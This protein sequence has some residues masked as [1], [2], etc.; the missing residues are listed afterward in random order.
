MKENDKIETQGNGQSEK[1]MVIVILCPLP[2]LLLCGFVG[3]Q[4]ENIDA[5]EGNKNTLWNRKI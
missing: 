4:T 2:S 1:E 3:P 5:P